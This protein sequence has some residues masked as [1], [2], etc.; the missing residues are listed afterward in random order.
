M[1]NIIIVGFGNIGRLEYDILE[2]LNP[3]KYDPKL[4]TPKYLQQLAEDTY[5]LA[6]ICV[7][8]PLN[9]HG[10]CDISI[11]EQAVDT[12]NAKV[13]LIKST[14]IPGTTDYLK[15]RFYK[16][17]KRIVMSPEHSGTTQHCNDFDYN[18]T[19]LGG[20]LE[21]CQYVQQIYQQVHNAYHK[22]MIVDA[23]TAELSKYMLNSYLAMKVTFCNEFAKICKSE[24]IS[25][26]QLR[27]C[28]ILDPRVEASHTFVYNDTPYWDSH[29][30]NKDIPALANYYDLPLMN[31]VLWIN[32]KDKEKKRSK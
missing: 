13:Y 28:F 8:T 32:N 21:D 14:V 6:V 3:K 5:D 27:E 22:F 20:E 4:Y 2:R 16:L 30:F 23:K 18:F 17:N 12:I 15:K 26:E 31:A 19:I 10:M 7:P 11:V 25:Y 29:C 9:E 1:P 24:N